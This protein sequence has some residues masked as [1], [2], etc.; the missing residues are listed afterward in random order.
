LHGEFKEIYRQAEGQ[1]KRR[2]KGGKRLRNLA[3]CVP[4][5]AFVVKYSSLHR[6]FP[7]ASAFGKAALNLWEKAGFRPL[8]QERFPKPTGFW[9]MLHLQLFYLPFE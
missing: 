9:E 4:L 8:F 3:L 6:G 1:A 7:K 2:A 5:R